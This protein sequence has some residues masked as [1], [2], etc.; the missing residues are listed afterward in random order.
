MNKLTEFESVKNEMLVED[1]E[2]KNVGKVY[3][4]VENN[5]PIKNPISAVEFALDIVQK[6]L[7]NLV[8]TSVA[9]QQLLTSKKLA[10]LLITSLAISD[11]SNA[12]STNKKNSNPKFS[13]K[14]IFF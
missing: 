4:L 13:A 12:L 11:L 3:I 1:K 2:D 14:S 5:E 8:R 6:M 9:N 7:G 10:T